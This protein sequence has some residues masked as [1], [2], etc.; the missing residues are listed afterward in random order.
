MSWD[1]VIDNI[2]KTKDRRIVAY[3]DDLALIIETQTNRAM[4]MV[5]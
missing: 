5:S 2:K 3:A 4:M 1:V